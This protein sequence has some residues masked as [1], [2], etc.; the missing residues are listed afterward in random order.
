MASP[1]RSRPVQEDGLTEKEAKFALEYLVDLNQTQAYLRSYTD[2]SYE[3]AMANSSKLMAKP[4][5]KDAIQREMTARARRTMITADSVIAD[6]DAVKS[7]CMQTTPVTDRKGEAVMVENPNGDL[8]PAYTFDA[9][10]AL[11]A[12]ELLGK[13]LVL[14]TDKTQLTGDITVSSGV[15]VVPDGGTIDDW[16]TNAATH[17]KDLKTSVSGSSTQIED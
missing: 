17:Q 8:V 1:E 12:L 2:A 9:A 14:F 11:K 13:H 16:E 4:R 3:T 10:G 5:V 15:L 7:R 6:I